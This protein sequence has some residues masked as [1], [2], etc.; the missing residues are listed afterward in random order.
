MI[1]AI[2]LLLALSPAAYGGQQD[3]TK[4]ANEQ[5]K[6]AQKQH[7]EAKKQQEKED[8][9]REKEARKQQEEAQK[10]QEE[11]RK[12]QEK[13]A[14]KREKEAKTEVKKEEKTGVEKEDK[15][16]EA[17][18]ETKKDVMPTGTP[19]LWKDPGDI[20]ARDLYLGPGGEAMKPDL[21]SVTFIETETGGYSVKYRVRDGSGKIWVVKVGKEAQ[22]ETTSVR[23]LWAM[24]YVSEISYLVPCVHISGAPAPRYKVERCEGDGF[25]NARFEARPESADRTVEWE[26]SNN[27]FAG[28]KEFKGLVILMGLLN[29][30]DLKT[31]NNKIIAVKDEATGQTELQ[32]VIS[33]LGAT[34]GK[35]GGFISH[36]RNQPDDYV[37]SKF[38][39]GVSGNTVKFAYGGKSG[40]LFNNITV[41]DAR[42]IGGMLSRLSDKQIADAFRAANY[43]AATVQL[44]TGAVR[45][46][47]NELVNIQGG[48]A[49]STH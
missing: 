38:V 12:Q 45:G 49:A 10:Q 1:L 7:E 46:K 41:D 31:S 15:V 24:G 39:K 22:P 3:Q 48:S 36:N 34:F 6:E 35:T 2:A 42:W 40:S 21:T 13:E 14:K 32:Y 25:A 29:N 18:V 4:D 8:K 11:A 26:W 19:V 33:D 44:L 28:T 30:W 20:S 37:K 9:K 17:K 5:E 16:K 43:D 27:P 23:L 47:I